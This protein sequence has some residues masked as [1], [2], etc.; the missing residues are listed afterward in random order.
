MPIKMNAAQT[1]KLEATLAEFIGD[2]TTAPDRWTMRMA[3][4]KAEGALEG[5]VEMGYAALPAE[6][7]HNRIDTA[8][9]KAARALSLLERTQVA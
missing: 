7:Q 6:A 9:R 2:I 3:K 5:M 8:A 4:A 1:R